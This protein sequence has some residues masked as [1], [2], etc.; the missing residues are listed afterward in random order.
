MVQNDYNVTFI[1]ERR[2]RGDKGAGGQCGENIV[3]ANNY[4]R[5]EVIVSAISSGRDLDIDVSGRAASIS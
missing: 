2:K 5:L 3:M 4:L 1:Q